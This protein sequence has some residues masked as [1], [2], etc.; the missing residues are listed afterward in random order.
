[1][2]IEA[3]CACTALRRA[4]RA[5]TAAYDAALRPVDLRITQFSILR[6]LERLGPVGVTRLALEAALDR[7]TM[8]RNLDP[9]ERRGLVR[10]S[11]NA[12]DQRER[13]AALTE[14]GRAALSAALPLW[15]AAQAR[16][17]TALPPTLVA[18][19]AGRLARLESP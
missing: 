16:V 18:D 10:L 3:P 12:A 11:V 8:G 17:E 13:V 14:T 7:S 9:L 1:M 5:V 6:I 2:S 4:T 15:Q 19:L